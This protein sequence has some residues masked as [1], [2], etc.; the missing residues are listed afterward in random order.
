VDR[1]AL[2]YCGQ[3]PATAQS[4]WKLYTGNHYSCHSDSS[5]RANR[6]AQKTVKKNFLGQGSFKRVYKGFDNK[7]V[8]EY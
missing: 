1:C 8:G 5:Q 4:A 6:C 2:Q 3:R 7:Q